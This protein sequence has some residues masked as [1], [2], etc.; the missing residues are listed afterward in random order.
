[1]IPEDQALR[2]AVHVLQA[3]LAKYRLEGRADPRFGAFTRDEWTS[4]QNFFFDVGVINKK[5]DVNEYFTNELI[6]GVNS[7]DK[8]AIVKKAESFR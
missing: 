5:P 1:N 4:T 8:A 6:D 2:E 3:R 7:F